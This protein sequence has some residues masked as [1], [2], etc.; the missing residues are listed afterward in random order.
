MLDAIPYKKNN[1]TMVVLT[2]GV[3]N[4]A[5]F[6]HSFLAQQMGIALVEGKDLYVEN[7][8]VYGDVEQGVGDRV[9][10]IKSEDGIPYKK[11]GNTYIFNASVFL[12]FPLPT[13]NQYQAWENYDF[14][15]PSTLVGELEK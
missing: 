9:Q 12:D 6:E 15:N 3:Y 11:L 1:P 4:S 5:Y 13:G 8:K 14:F 10:T 7:D 2:P